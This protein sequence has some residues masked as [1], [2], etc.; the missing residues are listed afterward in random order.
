MFYVLL[1]IYTVF[2]L[3]PCW[4]AGSSAYVRQADDGGIEHPNPTA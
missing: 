4:M 1:G 3:L 2:I